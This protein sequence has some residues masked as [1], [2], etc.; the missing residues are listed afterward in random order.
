MEHCDAVLKLHFNY[1]PINVLGSSSEN[2]KYKLDTSVYVEKQYLGTDCIESN[3]GKHID[4]KSQYM[5]ENPSMP[6]D[7]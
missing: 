4:M 6:I 2:R 7:S 1:M 3:I 5:N